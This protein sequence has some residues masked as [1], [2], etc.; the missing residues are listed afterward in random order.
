[1]VVMTNK[2]VLT[3]L[4]FV[5]GLTSCD[6]FNDVT[7]GNYSGSDTVVAG[8]S[9]IKVVA[10][11]ENKFLPEI[12]IA[13]PGQTLKIKIINKLKNG[14]MSFVVLKKDED[15]IVNAYLGIQAGES[16]QWAPPV[17][18]ILSKSKLLPNS[19][20]ES[21]EVVLPTEPGFYS[22]ISSYPGHVD[23]LK[24]LIKIED[25]ENNLATEDL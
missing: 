11:P 4:F 2:N 12:I 21:I 14:P 1:M 8:R 13:K 23:Y 5:M 16:E 20:S 7:Q 22:Y 25:P 19:E 18:H 24:G 10:T 3:V 6:W 17:E 9:E 15:P